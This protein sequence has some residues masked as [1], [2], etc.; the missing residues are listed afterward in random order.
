MRIYII[1]FPKH[2]H[3][4][5]PTWW[6]PAGLRGILDRSS[7]ELP[8]THRLTHPLT[9]LH[10]Y[11]SSSEPASS[12]L[13][14][15][16]YSLISKHTLNFPSSKSLV[17]MLPQWN[18]FPT[19]TCV[20]LSPVSCLLWTL[21][22]QSTGGAEQS[23]QRSQWLSPSL[24]S[25]AQCPFICALES[26]PYCPASRTPGLRACEGLPLLEEDSIGPTHDYTVGEQFWR[27]QRLLKDLGDTHTR[28]GIF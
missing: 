23:T 6:T 12:A 21:W 15:P 24:P 20:I 17:I 27:D 26:S 19:P 18:S 9:R 2:C 11:P 22:A 10:S 8:P 3:C 16:Y 1:P 7:G 28:E 14:D 13:D 4:S 25:P 5:W